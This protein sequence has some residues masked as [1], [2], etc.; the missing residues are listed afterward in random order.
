MSVDYHL[1]ADCICD[2][3]R[4]CEKRT[5]QAAR[6]VDDALDAIDA[7]GGTNG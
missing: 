2:R 5:L 4:A 7:L 6:D 1:G 3:L